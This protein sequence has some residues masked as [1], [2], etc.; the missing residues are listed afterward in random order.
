[1]CGVGLVLGMTG[2]D[3][4]KERG[5]VLS[6]GRSGL[7]DAGEPEVPVRPAPFAGRG[8]ADGSRS[9][10]APVRQ[11]GPAGEVRVT[12]ARHGGKNEAGGGRGVADSRIVRGARSYHAGLAAE[13]QVAQAYG[14][15]GIEVCARRW[16]GRSG[17]IDIVARD[18]DRVIFVE[19]KQS[20]TH[21]EAASHMT[22]R[23]MERVWSAA[24]EFLAGEPRGQL[25][26]VRID[27]ALVDGRG[28]I[29]IIENAYAA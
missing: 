6:W 15:V 11:T 12:E 24:S 1:M 4:A 29:E 20:R 16:R 8:V 5:L 25:T 19:V 3:R 23:Q 2:V 27:L 10:G 26:E 14:R 17:E 18:G 13:D 7:I 9:R 21:D 28:R 22:P